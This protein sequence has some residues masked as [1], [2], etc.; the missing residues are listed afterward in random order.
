MFSR[1]VNKEQGRKTRQPDDLGRLCESIGVAVWR[2]GDDCDIRIGECY[3]PR[4]GDLIVRST[5]PI[6]AYGEFLTAAA[7][8]GNAMANQSFLPAHTRA[9][10]SALA[11]ALETA[12]ESV[13]EEHGELNGEPK[14]RLFG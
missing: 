11:V 13:K 14:P 3:K 10:V 5:F 2:D 8:V 4:S 9:V 12:L 6:S 1:N 7:I